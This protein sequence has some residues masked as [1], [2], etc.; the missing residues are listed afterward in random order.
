MLFDVNI[1]TPNLSSSIN[2]IIS[3]NEIKWQHAKL[4]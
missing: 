2:L 1:H 3:K 4:I